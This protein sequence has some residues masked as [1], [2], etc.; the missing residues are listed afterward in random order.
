MKTIERRL[1]YF[2]GGIFLCLV[3]ILGVL[4]VYTSITSTIETITAMI[5]TPTGYT[6][7]LYLIRL[8]PNDVPNQY[9]GDVDFTRPDI[10]GI[11]G[12]KMVFYHDKFPLSLHVEQEVIIMGTSEEIT[13][14][15]T[16]ET[17]FWKDIS[18]QSLEASD[19][20]ANDISLGCSPPTSSTDSTGTLIARYCVAVALYDNVLVITRGFVREEQSLT[21]DEFLNLVEIADARVA[22]VFPKQKSS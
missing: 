17:A 13:K 8:K 2:V 16:A 20:Y 12:E 19:K 11:A 5:P 22:Q 14:S 10:K 7:E 18:F 9:L 21:M 3:I 4:L 1:V 15:A 6:D